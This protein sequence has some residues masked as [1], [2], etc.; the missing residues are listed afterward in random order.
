MPVILESLAHASIK[1]YT[2]YCGLFPC[3]TLMLDCEVFH[4]RD[5]VFIW[6]SLAL[7]QSPATL[8][9]LNK[10]L[11]NDQ[12]TIGGIWSDHKR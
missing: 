2:E 12:L 11:L 7:A 5:R 10:Y 8:E 1:A 3:L 9:I 6:E 4:G